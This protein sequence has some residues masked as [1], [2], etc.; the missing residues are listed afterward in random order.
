MNVIR[1]LII[2]LLLPVA[3]HASDAEKLT[4][5][6][7]IDIALEN[8]SELKLTEYSKNG[9]RAKMNESLTH[10]FPRL[11]S[12]ASY[13]RLESAPTAELPDGTVYPV[14]GKET[15][16]YSVS[17]TQPIFTGGRIKNGYSISKYEFESA[18]EEKSIKQKDVITEVTK[19]YFQVLKAKK[20]EEISISSRNLIE[21]HLKNVEAFYE[22]GIVSKNDLLSAKVSLANANNFLIKASNNYELAKSGLNFS[23]NQDLNSPLNLEDIDEGAPEQNTDNEDFNYESCV[24]KAFDYR[25][26]L[27][28]INNV[29]KISKSAV[30]LER[31]SYYPQFYAIATYGETGDDLPLNDDTSSLLVTAELDIF[32]WGGTSYRVES[33][34]IALKKAKESETLLRNSIQLEVKRAYLQLKQ[35]IEEINATKQAVEQAQE[36]YR[37][38]DEKFKVNAATSTDVLDAE[39][40]ILESKINYFQAL[41]NYHIAKIILKRA[42]GEINL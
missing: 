14:A 9:A 28:I 26:E 24:E 8:N 3:V 31:S 25:E 17:L 2:A 6:E 39:N 7:C 37:I 42:T 34:K 21:S 4:L 38:F 16:E 35:S 23:L 18:K 13:L 1:I 20:F 40:L 12:S 27:N 15:Y 32:S 33:S 22:A 29:K 41:Y 36:N 19:N 5:Q 30:N 10:F 11:T